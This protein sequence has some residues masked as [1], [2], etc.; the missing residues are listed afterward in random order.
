MFDSKGATYAQRLAAEQ[1]QEDLYAAQIADLQRLASAAGDTRDQV[2]GYMVDMAVQSPEIFE[3]FVEM[4]PQALKLT[5]D[6]ANAQ[7]VLNGMYT[8]G[9]DTIRQQVAAKQEQLALDAKLEKSAEQMYKPALEVLRDAYSA[10]GAQGFVKAWEMLPED[11]IE[12][13]VTTYGSS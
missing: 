4:Y 7:E 1:A 9:L 12:G 11:Q 10:G 13:L 2:I 5:Q 3:G 8:Q 6:G